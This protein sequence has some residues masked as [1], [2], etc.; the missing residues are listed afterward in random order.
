VVI[1]TRMMRLIEGAG[2]IFYIFD[3]LAGRYIFLMSNN[4]WVYLCNHQPSFTCIYV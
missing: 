2:L 1:M 3:Y 4:Y